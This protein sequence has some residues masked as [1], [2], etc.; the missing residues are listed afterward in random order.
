MGRANLRRRHL[1]AGQ[2][3]IVAAGLLPR[4][5]EEAWRRM[6]A[7]K[8]A[9]GDPRAG[10]HEGSAGRADRAA[11]ALFGVSGRSVAKA[12]ALTAAAPDLAAQVWAGRLTLERAC[13]ELRK[14]GRPRRR[15]PA[16]VPDGRFS[17]VY[18]EVAGVLFDGRNRLAACRRADIATEPP[19][20]RAPSRRR[21]RRR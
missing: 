14:R 2:R 1:D 21:F 19:P 4:F 5:E 13:S 16:A 3:A 15:T 12:R 20:L 17:V 7:G 10:L 9:T 8:K 11:G 18:A 6:L